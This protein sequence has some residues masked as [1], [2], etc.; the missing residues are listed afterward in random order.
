M[1]RIKAL[2]G[3]ANPGAE[4]E[5]TRHNAGAWLIEEVARQASTSLRLEKKF[6]GLYAKV[7]VD[8][9][10]LHLLMPTTFM[11]RSGGAVA[12]L[13]NFFKLAPDEILVAHDEL[14]L[15]PGCARYKQG[16]G[17]G[18]HNGLRDII[19]ALGNDKSFHRVRIGIGHPGNASMVTNYVLGRP[20]KSE[21]E[22]IDAS[23]E[24]CMATLPLALGGDWAKAMN[25][26]HSFS[27]G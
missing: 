16:G 22:A 4:Y 8:G 27:H 26:L 2:I 10:D 20:G 17:H 15:P 18:G 21:R 14:D 25:R 6:L 9:Q 7:I 24:E 13:A 12:A 11:N 19:S 3:L 1:A 5:A 23:I